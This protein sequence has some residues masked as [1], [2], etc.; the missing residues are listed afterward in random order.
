MDDN[1]GRTAVI[2]GASSG[3]GAAVAVKLAAQ[4]ARVALVARRKDRVEALRDQIG[5]RAV[6]VAADVSNPAEVA[7]ARERVA[8]EL[9]RVDLVV[10]A[11]GILVP[12]L[13]DTPDPDLPDTS[14][15][16]LPDTPTP[17][18]S[19][20][21]LPDTSTT[22]PRTGGMPADWRRQ[23]DVNVAGLLHVFRAFLPDLQAAA[24]AGVPADL[25]N[26]SSVAASRIE[27]GAAVYAAT[28]AAV[29]HLSR[30]I[31][32]ELAP[33]NIRVTNLEP[34]VVVT[35]LLSASELGT[36]WLE[37]M[38]TRIDPLAAADLAEV[39]AFAVSR[40]IH[41]SLPEITV[42]PTRQV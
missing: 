27:P 5:E 23:L 37:D 4:G 6:A 15:P 32:N 34:G 1:T 30:N 31:R 19:A 22:G 35:E 9:G 11:A 29:S 18:L 24:A 8:R 20:S 38:K 12:G 25:V 40:P 16:G 36:A 21:R 14:A 28:K 17:G 33:R 26:I 39:V 13:L 7:A 41:V 42:V 10:N 3:I 2:T